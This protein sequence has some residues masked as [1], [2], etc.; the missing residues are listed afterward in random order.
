MFILAISEETKMLMDGTPFLVIACGIRYEIIH[1]TSLSFDMI[2]EI[3]Q[4]IRNGMA[5]RM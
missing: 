1:N 5:V 2:D 3:M 4:Q